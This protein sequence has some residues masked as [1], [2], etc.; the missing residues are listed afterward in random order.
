MSIASCPT[1]TGVTGLSRVCYFDSNGKTYAQDDTLDVLPAAAPYGAMLVFQTDYIPR[2]ADV[3]RGGADAAVQVWAAPYD[4]RSQTECCAEENAA[5]LISAQTSVDSAHGAVVISV[6]DAL[7]TGDQVAIGI[8]FGSLYR[9]R[10]TPPGGGACDLP[11]PAACADV[12]LTSFWMRF[13]VGAAPA[14]LVTGPSGPDPATVPDGACLLSYNTALV[15]GD[16]CCYRKG[17]AN[18]CNPRIQCN[19][20]SGSGCC[21]I[22]GTENTKSGQRCCLYADGGNVDGADECDQLLAAK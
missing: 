8:D 4:V 5:N 7:P 2:E 22:Y 18:T 11:S 3:A 10:L 6:P 17:A 14:G 16:D 1:Y 19:A 9:E 21:L 13:Y 12:G 15:S 20:A